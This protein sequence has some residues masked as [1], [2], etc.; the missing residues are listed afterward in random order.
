MMGK[1]WKPNDQ[2]FQQKSQLGKSNSRREGMEKII[3]ASLPRAFLS[4]CSVTGGWWE[5]RVSKGTGVL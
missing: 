1:R 4:F 3:V 5:E 2:Q